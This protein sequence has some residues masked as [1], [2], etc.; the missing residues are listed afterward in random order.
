[1]ITYVRARHHPP[2]PVHRAVKSRPFHGHFQPLPHRLGLPKR[3]Q[4]QQWVL[5][6]EE[7]HKVIFLV[8]HNSEE[9]DLLA[10]V[11]TSEVATRVHLVVVKALL[12]Q[13]GTEKSVP[14]DE[15][16][17]KVLVEPPV[18]VQPVVGGRAKN[19]LEPGAGATHKACVHPELIPVLKSHIE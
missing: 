4:R 18:M 10:I 14:D 1:M 7:V 16:S 3:A 5:R 13:E 19:V 9:R 17:P 6:L 2:V 15:N 12:V 8:L 11:Q